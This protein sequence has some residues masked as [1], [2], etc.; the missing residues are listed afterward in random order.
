MFKTKRLTLRGYR[1]S[2]EE[3]FLDLF[4]NYNVI[5]NLADE[6]A[7]PNLGGHRDMLKTMIKCALFVVVQDSETCETIGFTLLS[8]STPRNLDGD[9][10]MALA[11]KHWGKGYATEILEWLKDYSF[12]VLGLRRLS[13]FVFSSNK[14]ATSLYEHSGFLVEGRIR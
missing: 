1:P 8:I 6:Y 11:E 5:V 13:L 2:D 14:R 9:L 4:D 7:A 3:F 12:K 10:G